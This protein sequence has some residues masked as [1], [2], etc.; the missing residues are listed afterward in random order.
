[1]GK[2]TIKRVKKFLMFEESV[3]D[4]IRRP[5]NGRLTRRAPD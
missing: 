3:L 2:T 4:K 1:M 5:K